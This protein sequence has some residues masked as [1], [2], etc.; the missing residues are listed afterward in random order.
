MNRPDDIHR[1]Y[2]DLLALY[3]E[4]Q[5][6]GRLRQSDAHAIERELRA[7]GTVVEN[8]AALGD[9]ASE[10]Q[11]L[12]EQYRRIVTLYAMAV[13]LKKIR[14]EYV[15]AVNAELALIATLVSLNFPM[16]FDAA[17]QTCK[18]A[19]APPPASTA[20]V[21]TPIPHVEPVRATRLAHGGFS[22][23]DY[24]RSIRTWL[25]RKELLAAEEV[26][27]N[28][29]KR[30]EQLEEK[31]AAFD[32][33]KK[34]WLESVK[35]ELGTL[36]GTNAKLRRLATM[37]N[38]HDLDEATERRFDQLL[39]GM[40]E[41][42][43]GLLTTEQRDERIAELMPEIFAE[44]DA[45]EQFYPTPLP[46]IRAYVLAN[47]DLRPEMSILEPSAGKGNI[48]DAVRGECPSCS[49]DVIELNDRRAELLQLKGY[50]LVG[51]DT[52]EY[53][54][55]QYDRILM[56]PPFLKV[57]GIAH[58]EHCFNK[59]LKPGGTLVAILN[60]GAYGDTKEVKSIS[61]RR[62]Y[63]EKY[64]SVIPILHEEYN[65]EIERKIGIDIAVVILQKP[66]TEEVRQ[67]ETITV[68]QGM[69]L[70]NRRTQSYWLV[71]SIDEDGSVLLRNERTNETNEVSELEADRWSVAPDDEAMLELPDRPES[72][73]DTGFQ[74]P[75]IVTARQELTGKAHGFHVDREL[76][77]DQIKEYVVEGANYAIEALRDRGG[78]LL[79]DGT[80]TGKTIQQLLIAHYWYLS[81]G[82]PVLIFTESDQIIQQSFFGDAQKLGLAAPDK[83]NPKDKPAR[84]PAEYKGLYD[85][86]EFEYEAVPTLQ[87]GNVNVI[88]FL[89]ERGILQGINVG[90]YND[91][92]NIKAL[93]DH[94]AERA[95]IEA[96]RKQK[97]AKKEYAEQRK[98]IRNT[99]GLSQESKNKAVKG[100][101]DAEET[102]RRTVGVIEA[103]QAWIDAQ[104]QVL[105]PWVQSISCLIYDEA[106]NLKNTG[107]GGSNRATRAEMLSDNA[108][109]V[110][111]V[112]ATPADK[113]GDIQY[114]KQSGIYQSP[115]Q[116][117]RIMLSIGYGW[118]AER[119]NK[120]EEVIRRGEFK[121][122]SLYSPELA[123]RNL[124]RVFDSLTE[125]RQMLKREIELSNLEDPTMLDVP[126]DESVQTLM[127]D[128][129]E[130]MMDATD[131][132]ERTVSQ[133]EILMEQK[134]ALEPYKIDKCV[135]IAR[136]E[137]TQGRSVVIF[138]DLVEEGNVEKAWG[139]RKAGTVR[140]LKER[141][142]KLI[143]AEKIGLVIGIASEWE[144]QERL[145][146]I[147]AFQRG[148]KRVMLCTI[149]SGGTGISLDDT[150]GNAPRTIIIMTA[151]MNSIKTVQVMGRVV[152]A[153]TRSRSRA[154]FL[155]ADIDIDEWLKNLLATK[156]TMLGA[157]VAGQVS[158]YNPKT[159]EAMEAGGDAG[160]AAAFFGTRQA[161]K[162]HS[163]FLR[164]PGSWIDGAELPQGKPL[165]V[166]RFR[167]GWPRSGNYVRIKGTS[168]T[169]I[170]RFAD[171]QAEQVVK[172]GMEKVSDRYEG[173]YYQC[174]YS[175]EAW[176]WAL[177]LIKVENL[178]AVTNPR[179]LFAVG[180]SVVA[181]ED[182]TLS[183]TAVGT[184]GTVT[185]VRPRVGYYLYDV[186][187]EDGTS[188][189]SIDQE[190]L[191][192][193]VR[194]RVGQTF[195]RHFERQY[196]GGTEQARHR[197]TIIAIHDQDDDE[198]QL[199]DVE[200]AT[201][202]PVDDRW[203]DRA[204]T[205]KQ[206]TGWNESK[207]ES[208]IEEYKLTCE[209]KCGTAELALGDEPDIF[210]SRQAETPADEAETS[211]SLPDTSDDEMPQVRTINELSKLRIP[212]R[213]LSPKFD[214]LFGRLR[215]RCRYFIH[216]TAGHGKS[217]LALLFSEEIGRQEAR[218]GKRVL[219][220]NAE[221]PSDAGGMTD[222]IN[223]I[224]V[225]SQNVDVV[226][227]GDP[228]VIEHYLATGK[229]SLIVI[230]SISRV[231]GTEQEKVKFMLRMY[232]LF[233]E[234]SFML[235]AHEEKNNRT[236]KGSSA[237]AHDADIWVRVEKGIATTEKGPPGSVKIID[238]KNDEVRALRK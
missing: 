211:E 157:V 105:T 199:F 166:G 89:P 33:T 195:T 198:E 187:F 234:V 6:R 134:R 36:R 5:V 182:I 123:A 29:R 153:N 203:I 59:L 69:R 90:T 185:A 132:D 88:R 135:E 188:G 45:S 76:L 159:V 79:A 37:Y 64:G 31:P 194:Y 99:K 20:S 60:A 142:A 111:F 57:V 180:Q 17:I 144:R 108:P 210:E 104:R 150:I 167:E 141:L 189:E 151:P 160:V 130:A 235:I 127:H 40:W 70:M 124:S 115:E 201:E 205:T 32:G 58:V 75:S 208:V 169:D 3:G 184:A 227:T 225:R 44:E 13:C 18:P 231:E 39:K 162:E 233:P 190:A 78:F 50:H 11:A 8:N 122:I 152:R 53:T 164:K 73:I 19:E 84:R 193:D 219:Y 106:H 206:Q 93:R 72:E 145:Q 136:R 163:M 109:R 165:L 52:L 30:I 221:Q 154:Y 65:K 215:E 128:I 10:K 226:D 156:L 54:G 42:S 179:Q 112:S 186:Q 116:F 223:F 98:Q 86:E 126:I 55:K 21:P 74:T 62:N 183:G 191:G 192:V 9:R 222:R 146:H 83:F 66:L 212:R 67:K 85:G 139:D 170:K 82:K 35:E 218:K 197:L 120:F 176:T 23:P 43:G 118:Y 238:W 103:E 12:Q 24:A 87:D 133:A 15:S 81:T 22:L 102:D 232:R 110:M 71:E 148:E 121:P 47:A 216:G 34:E 213:H 143:G 131:D 48:A 230:D 168:L 209:I 171:E 137:L 7:I 214:K 56:N 63:I 25:M 196:Q 140:V 96:R 147:Q 173:T 92:S 41:K 202:V 125:K 177:N 107:L 117:K 181:L 27:G 229:Y 138:A 220:I 101:R 228:V 2:R 38:N 174:P 95:L 14:T 200:V 80:G 4:A 236:Y 237:F 172:F 129:E 217:S 46:V 149:G 158:V 204:G 16:L 161:K 28:N 94:P 100:V 114:L 61:F 51:R 119:R 178:D 155:F 77:N 49:I 175:D 224:G 113:P 68:S 26:I 97:E 1:Q 91:L 207:L